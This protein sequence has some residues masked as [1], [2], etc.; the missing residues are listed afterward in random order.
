[1]QDQLGLGRN[2]FAWVCFGAVIEQ[3]QFRYFRK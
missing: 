2:A 1:M 3:P